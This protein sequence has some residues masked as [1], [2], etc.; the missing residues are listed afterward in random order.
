MVP[1]STRRGLLG[2]AGATTLAALAGCS[3]AT[4]FGADDGGPGYSLTVDAVDESLVEYA[5]YE[6]DER[7]EGADE[8]D[9]LSAVLPDGRHTTYGYRPVPDEAYV[10]HEGSYY[11]VEYAVTGRT[12]AERPV[13]RLDPVAETDVPGDALP[14]DDVDEPS[15]SV[16]G[17]LSLH[18]DHGGVFDADDLRDGGVVLR[19]PPDLDDRLATG[20]LDGR[21]VTRHG[22]EHAYRVRV[23]R[24]SAVETV[25]TAL[26]VEVADSRAAFREVVL[27][28]RVDAELAP[29]DL[30]PDV[31][32]LLDGTV[33]GD[34]YAETAPLPRS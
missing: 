13:G 11:G 34:T 21:V 27:G 20:D 6:P 17:L 9:P 14:V 1:S 22:P 5:L 2:T 29:D 30:R 4:L 25:Y 28:S 15:R 23:T 10:D 26:A 19:R 8:R 31:R 16:L 3:G 33:A 18:V 7:P 24:E 12:P 32:R